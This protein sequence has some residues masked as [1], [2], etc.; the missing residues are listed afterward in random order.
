MP[1][2][3]TLSPPP[4]AEVANVVAQA[5][6]ATYTA[7]DEWRQTPGGIGLR[8]TPAAFGLFGLAQRS[9]TYARKH[10]APYYAKGR[11]YRQTMAGAG[12]IKQLAQGAAGWQVS[13]TT[14]AARGLNFMRAGGIYFREWITLHP[15]EAA[16]IDAGVQRRL[17]QI[18]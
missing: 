16:A 9:P 14:P 1:V 2:A 13:S 4:Q 6:R 10:P 15:R 18:A 8:F 7:L 11:F 12:S 5:Q 17:D 3:G